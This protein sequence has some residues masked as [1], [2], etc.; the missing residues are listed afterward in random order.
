MN[1]RLLVPLI[2]LWSLPAYAQWVSDSVFDAH[3]RQ[4]I[5]HIY[6]LAFEKAEAEFQQLVKLQPTHPAGHFFLA[7]VEWWRILMDIDNTAYD[8]KFYSMLDRVIRLCDRRL[9]KD[10]NDVTALFFKGGSIGFRGRLR[11]HREEWLKAANDG[12]LALPIVQKANRL[13]PQNYD[14]LLGIGIYNYYAEIVP[15]Q[16][17]FVKPAMIFFPKGDK[18]KGIE[19][20]RAASEKAK[21]ADIEAAYFLLQLYHNFE[22]D[23][24]QALGLA[25]R[26]HL[27]FPNNPIFHRYLGRSYAAVGLW[28]EMKTTFEMVLS[29]VKLKQVGY[30]VAAEREAEY[31]LGLHAMTFNKLE[32]AVRRFSRCD[33]LSRGLDKDGPSGFMTMANLKLGM[34]YDLLAKRD[35]AVSQYQK[36]L[37]WDDY[38][39]S[40]RIAS[41]YIK[42]PYGQ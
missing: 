22:K 26:L 24:N 9:D 39:D 40:R 3:T 23:Y 41:Q 29:R 32:E 34:V 17:P 42:K 11:A 13:S 4:G 2:L 14:V 30:G 21:Y 18:Q 31:Y 7:M 5:E 20:L 10:E 8:E 1:L 38:M 35:V 19:Q 27:R 6:N 37:K 25:Q 28:S 33:E 16:Y 15:E 36:V 12:R